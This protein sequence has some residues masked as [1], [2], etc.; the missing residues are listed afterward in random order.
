MTQLFDFSQT[1]FHCSDL[2]SIVTKPKS[3]DGVSEGAK[4]FLKKYYAEVKYGKRS[5]WSEKGNKFT[6]KGKDSEQ[7]SIDLVSKLENIPLYKNDDMFENDF[8]VGVP[9]ILIGSLPMQ[10]EMYVIDIK[11]SWDAGTFFEKLDSKLDLGYWWQ[12]QGYMWL[13]GASEG[14]V[15]YCLVNTPEETIQNE[16]YGMAIRMNSITQETAE[17]RLAEAKLRFNM[18]FDDI[19]EE[20]RRIKIPV[21]RDES[22]I[23]RIKEIVPK[24]REY[25]AELQNSH[26]KLCSIGV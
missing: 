15:S 6:R 10:P 18:T 14:E 7:D 4:T 22:A 1:K 11:T 25:L 2:Y 20:E 26:L 3:G 21:I 19:P 8:I 5:L 16:L 23:D 13:T 17:F 9:D 12:L 24:C